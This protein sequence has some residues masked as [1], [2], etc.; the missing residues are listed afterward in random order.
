M[1][2][3][4]NRLDVVKAS[5]SYTFIVGS[6]GVTQIQDMTVETEQNFVPQFNVWINGKIKHTYVN[7]VFEVEYKD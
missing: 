1:S 2:R 7:G 5:G 3:K 6:G 4:I